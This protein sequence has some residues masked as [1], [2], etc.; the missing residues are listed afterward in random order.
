MAVAAGACVSGAAGPVVA[1]PSSRP[2][3]RRSACRPRGSPASTRWFRG[4]PGL[5]PGPE[6]VAARR[7]GAR[8]SGGRGRRRLRFGPAAAS[9]RHRPPTGRRPVRPPAWRL[10]VRGRGKI[11]FQAL[12]QRFLAVLAVAV[13]RVGAAEIAQP[14][15]RRH[16]L[17][18][19]GL[20]QHFEGGEAEGDDLHGL[21]Q[22]RPGARAV[23]GEGF[24]DLRLGLL[25][26][27]GD[28][29][30]IG[31]QVDDEAVQ[32]G[33]GSDGVRA[34]TWAVVRVVVYVLF[35]MASGRR[36]QEKTHGRVVFFLVF[37][38]VPGR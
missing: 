20:G 21:D 38:L 15:R 23:G 14:Q 13:E 8:P 17:I 37:L 5:A 6:A 2:V 1:W 7:R 36:K 12:F 27:V 19:L 24:E 18:G 22:F 16:L 35:L 25:L 30:E 31:Q 4:E 3:P 32:E 34:M 11:T 28:G 33:A 10:P 9:R 29:Q 26:I